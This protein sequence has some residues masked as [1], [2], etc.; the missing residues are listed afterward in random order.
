MEWPIRGS[1]GDLAPRAVNVGASHSRR[2]RSP[3]WTARRFI[4]QKL[5]AMDESEEAYACREQKLE[6]L[7]CRAQERGPTR[8]SLD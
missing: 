8:G 5:S 3:T 1:R 4:S 7:P 2:R 6:A